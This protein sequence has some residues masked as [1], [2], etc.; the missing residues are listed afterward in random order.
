MKR[1][2][3][4][5][6]ACVLIALQDTHATVYNGVCG[7]HLTWTFDT[8]EGT[9]VIEG[10]G[11]MSPITYDDT[12]SWKGRRLEGAIRSVQLPEGITSIGSYAFSSCVSLKN[13]SIPDGVTTIKDQAFYDS[14]LTSI[15]LPNSVT[16][17]GVMT[18]RDCKN[19]TSCDLGRGIKN[20]GK[21][22]FMDCTALTSIKW[23]DCLETI[24]SDCFSAYDVVWN[25]PLT[26]PLQDTLVFPASFRSGASIFYCQTNVKVIVWNARH[27]EG[28]NTLYNYYDCFDD[29]IIG[30]EVEII[31]GGLFRNQTNIDTIILPESVTSIGG[32]AFNN[33][34][35]LKYVNIP[36]GVNYI[37]S[38]AFYNCTA[39]PS[40]ELPGG[41]EEIYTNTFYNCKSLKRLNIPEG[42]QAIGQ[43]AFQNCLVLDSVVLPA[44]LRTISESAFAG[45]S[46]PKTLVIPDKVITIAGSAFQNWT[47][48][49]ELTLG[50]Q[51]MLLGDKAFAGDKAV[52]QI[53]VLSG[54]PPIIS[55][56][57]FEGV[58]DSA[59][60]SVI[61]GTEA[62]Y[63]KDANWSRFRLANL[64]EE[65]YVPTQVTVEAEQTT[66]LFTWPTDAS[67]NSYQIDIYK[68]GTKF[69]SLTLDANGRLLG[70]AFALGRGQRA[71]ADNQQSDDDGQPYALSFM[72]TGLDKASRYSYVLSTLDADGKPLHVYIGDFA[73]TGYEGELQ[74][75]EG[76]EV[77]PTPPIIPG[78]PDAQQVLTGTEQASVQTEGG[79]VT[80]TA[81]R[82][83]HDGQLLIE[84][85][86]ELYNAAGMRLR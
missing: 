1:S 47:S 61:P 49:E 11:D 5:M 50:K 75:P 86:G 55:S 59:W 15:A 41:I 66:A 39:L 24:G 57:T 36:A 22:C 83:L 12:T 30:P 3:A 68:D 38:S 44:G 32:N 33:C 65:L 74:Y 6:L 71:D 21:Q 60:L 4:Y 37:G 54:M 18:F 31:P 19:L 35:K 48:L 62:L 56:G 17:I 84:R 40:L 29:I 51:L 27:P 52:K 78:D 25:Q 58:P 63:Q 70:I 16:D 13:I 23:S 9:L 45:M 85:G 46:T 76:N 2:I 81:R 28:G 73:T 8:S 79:E 42:V 7:E 69:C 10:Y 14:G 82:L 53:Q 20:I 72:V 67:A 34:T 26:I 80:R 77:M 64:P 43:S